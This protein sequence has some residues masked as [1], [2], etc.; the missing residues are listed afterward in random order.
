MCRSPA[1]LQ[2]SRPSAPSA[3]T[4]FV[5]DCSLCRRDNAGKPCCWTRAP[6]D[7]DDGAWEWRRSSAAAHRAYDDQGT[8][9]L[10]A[11]R[12][13]WGT[14]YR[15]VDDDHPDARSVPQCLFAAVW[16]AEVCLHAYKT[17]ST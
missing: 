17:C 12:Y 16:C 7:L 13:A 10:R 4:V 14:T 8:G 5:C 2:P 1:L 11:I 9:Q 6:R 3:P 15:R